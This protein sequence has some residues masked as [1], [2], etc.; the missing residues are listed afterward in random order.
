[1][2]NRN[3]IYFRF[4]GSRNWF[5]IHKL[6]TLNSNC[7]ICYLILMLG[8]KFWA[9]FS[10]SCM[11]GLPFF[12]IITL[13]LIFDLIL[14]PSSRPWMTNNLTPLPL[15]VAENFQINIFLYWWGKSSI[16]CHMNWRCPIGANN[17]CLYFCVIYI[18]WN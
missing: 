8:T 17:F 9:S 16:N 18:Q 4:L 7:V 11:I 13:H 5:M 1:M 3:L 6:R 14:W 10:E 12:I 15:E 2:Q